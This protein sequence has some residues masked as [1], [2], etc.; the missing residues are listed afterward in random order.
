M[1]LVCTKKEFAY[2]S[3]Y[4]NNYCGK[5]TDLP[6]FRSDESARPIIEK[7]FL[8][9]S[10]YTYFEPIPPHDRAKEAAAR[11]DLNR[12]VGAASMLKRDILQIAACFYPKAPYAPLASSPDGFYYCV[13]KDKLIFDAG[14]HPS[15]FFP[16]D[17]QRWH[18]DYLKNEGEFQK[19]WQEI[20]KKSCPPYLY[21]WNPVLPCY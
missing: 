9:S 19:R 10:Y 21:R 8:Y 14:Y 11:T 13:D 6:P 4:E 3:E 5:H 16:D 7:A 17:I 12:Y 20:F 2:F 18:E 15:Y 1:A